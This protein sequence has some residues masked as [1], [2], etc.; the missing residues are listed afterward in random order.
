[1][2]GPDLS[3]LE[4]TV[5]ALAGASAPGGCTRA[6]AACAACSP[7]MSLIPLRSHFVPRTLEGRLATVAFVVLFLLAM[8]PVTHALWDRPDRWIAGWPF[9]FVVLFLVYSGLVAILLWALRRG[10]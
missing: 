1:M 7:A 8:P 9:F 10:V 3:S 4:D 5:C 2:V 6:A